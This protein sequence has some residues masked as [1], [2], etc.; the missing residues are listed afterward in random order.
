VANRNCLHYASGHLRLADKERVMTEDLISI[1]RGVF[2][3]YGAK[4]R[5]AIEAVIADDFHFTSPLDNRIDRQ[6][7][8]ERCWKNSESIS[9]FTFINLAQRLNRRNRTLFRLV[10]SARSSGRGLCRSVRSTGVA[11]DRLWRP[12]LEVAKS[13]TGSASRPRP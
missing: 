10:D 7:F 11:A 13:Q 2:E 12:V 5:A 1:V 4:D 9:G 6:T 3:A 8:F